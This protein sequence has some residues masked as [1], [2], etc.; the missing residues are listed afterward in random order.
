MEIVLQLSIGIVLGCILGQKELEQIYKDYK[1]S[2]R[3]EE[4]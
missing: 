4:I 1:N 3:E 2:K